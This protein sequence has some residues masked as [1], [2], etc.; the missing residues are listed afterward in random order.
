M[1]AARSPRAQDLPLGRRCS[2]DAAQQQEFHQGFLDVQAVLGFVPDY[3]LGA[4][5]DFAGD[6]LA[7]GAGRQCMNTAWG[8]AAAIWS[9]RVRPSFPQHE[10][11]DVP[12]SFVG[13]VER[14]SSWARTQVLNARNPCGR[15]QIV[16]SADAGRTVCPR[17]H[18]FRALESGVLA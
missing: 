7:A 6:F 15:G 4:V 11:H 13:W 12:Q 8:S 3:A 10:P 14:G 1:L 18:G 17:P 2:V 16:F 5:D 9:S